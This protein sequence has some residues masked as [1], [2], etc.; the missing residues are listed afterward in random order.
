ML[1]LG[2]EAFDTADERCLGG[3][4]ALDLQRDL[5]GSVAVALRVRTRDILRPSERV[6]LVLSSRTRRIL[7]TFTRARL[8]EALT[9]NPGQGVD[10]EDLARDLVLVYR[11]Q[12]AL[13]VEIV[14]ARAEPIPLCL[15]FGVA[16]VGFV[17]L[18]L[19]SAAILLGDLEGRAGF[20]KATTELLKLALLDGFRLTLR[21]QLLLAGEH[22]GMQVLVAFDPQPPPPDP[23]AVA[24]DD[25]LS[26]LERVALRERL[27]QRFR[28]STRPGQGSRCRRPAR[29]YSTA[30]AAS[31]RARCASCR[32]HSCR[33]T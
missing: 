33:R 5:E 11:E 12:L 6:A 8:C 14:P 23:H 13:A 19:T 18:L 26:G 17:E 29:P 24:R 30:A 28:G 21:P 7:D 25:R 9:S 10:L 2:R 16:R 31:G 22:T 27:A 4:V 1:A 32:A 15:R 20:V 3:A